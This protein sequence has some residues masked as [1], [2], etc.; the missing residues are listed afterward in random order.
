V[1]TPAVSRYIR[2]GPPPAGEDGASE[3]GG[4]ETHWGVVED[5]VVHELSDPPFGGEHRSG[6]RTPLEDVRVRSPSLPSKVIAVGRNFRSHLGD[7]EAPAEP[8]LFAKLPS[9]IIG[10]GESIVLPPDARDVH[11]EG[12]LVVVI[13]KRARNV[14]PEE[15]ADYIF[16]VTGGNDVSARGWQREDLQWLRAKASDTFAPVGP[17]IV[18]DLNYGDL[19]LQTHLNGELVQSER[20]ADLI[21]SIPY[22]ISY[23]SRYFTLLP[24]DVIFTGTPGSTSALSPGDRVEIEIEGVGTLINPVISAPAE[25]NRPAP[26]PRG[27]ET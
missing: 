3:A 2:Y 23:A 4:S 27:N 9:A 10:P 20:S 1:E 14:D 18:T 8:G 21:F 6:I 5:G 19:L 22:V 13:G 16:G 15:A 24:G 17:A 26:E 11:F 25:S 7:R 12:E